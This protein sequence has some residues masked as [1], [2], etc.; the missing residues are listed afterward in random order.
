MNETEKKII[1]TPEID[2]TRKHYNESNPAH[3]TRAD[4]KTKKEKQLK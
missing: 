4:E 2:E 3:V 1:K